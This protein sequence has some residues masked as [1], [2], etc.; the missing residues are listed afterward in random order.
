M[1]RVTIVGRPVPERV[2]WAVV[3]AV[4]LLVPV[5]QGLLII[6]IVL[7]PPVALLALLGYLAWTWRLRARASAFSARSWTLATWV[8]ASTIGWLAAV[9]ILYGPG[10]GPDQVPAAGSGLLVPVVVALS[11]GAALGAYLV[12]RRYLWAGYREEPGDRIGSN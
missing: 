12:A 5:G 6:T 11:V 8:L 9:G 3:G 7:A 4:G 2:V 10:R 1:G